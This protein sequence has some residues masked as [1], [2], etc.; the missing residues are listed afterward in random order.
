MA[1][2]KQL[3]Q[4]LLLPDW[5]AAL[6]TLPSFGWVIWQLVS[7]QSN[8]WQAYASYGLS[9]YSL[10]LVCARIPGIIRAFRSHFASHPIIQAA[11]H[12]PQ[13]QLYRGDI[14]YRKRLGLYLSLLINLLNA[15]FH[16]IMGLMQRSLWSGA[17]AG[18]YLLLT[19]MRAL[20]ARYAWKHGTGAHPRAEWKQYLGCGVILLVMNQALGVVVALVVH[21]NS[22]F[23]YPGV[24]IYAAA[25]YT[26]Y[27]VIHAAL[28]IQ[29]TRRQASPVLL[30]SCMV[31]LVAALVS[32]LSL[33]T[34]MLAQFGEDPVFR[35][36][37]TAVTGAVICTLVL[38]AAIYMIVHSAAKLKQT[39]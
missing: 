19:W 20:L 10:A 26:F 28:S 15:V 31:S 18:Y 12:A 37:M 24:M 7:G 23:T 4:R 6:V 17:L 29:Q 35:Q 16:L 39:A 25:L 1:R 32:L 22:H 9:A 27:A 11:A 5:L 14:A 2:L 13:V 8:S 33:E 34:A 30:A 38:G 21:R 3:W 36:A